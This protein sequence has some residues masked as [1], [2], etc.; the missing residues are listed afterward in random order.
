MYRFQTNISNDEYDTFVKNSSG[1]SFMQDY[2]WSNVKD[3]FNKILCGIYDNEQL[4]CAFTVLIRKIKFNIK[5]MYIPRGPQ[6]D[7][8]NTK[9]LLFFKTNVKKLAIEYKA[10]T[11]IIDPNFCVNEK[12]FK[13]IDNINNDYPVNFAND[14]D[15]KHHNIL[16]VG[17]IHKGFVKGL[18]ESFQ[19]RY[20]MVINLCDNQNNILNIDEVTKNYKSKVRYYLGDFH[21]KRG[22][23][24]IRT[25]SP[26]DV[27]KFVEML[28]YTESRQKIHLRNATYFKKILDNFKERA[29]LVFGY[30]DLNKYLIYLKQNN[31]KEKDILEIEDL[32]KKDDK[33]LLSASLTILPSNNNGIKIAEYLYAGNNLLLPNLRISTGMVYELMNLAI[34][35]KCHYLNLGGVSGYLNDHLTEFKAK[36]NPILFE[37][38][39][40]YELIIN[41]PIYFISKI[42]YKT[43]CLIKRKKKK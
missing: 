26:K 17:F 11:I 16:N 36:F 20:N 19:P 24:F 31:S 13:N 37:Y 22:V 28:N 3:N 33:I 29:V 41:K 15:E 5:L 23:Y 2:R 34:E 43:I 6:L 4:I 8:K 14:F 25:S 35:N 1:I 10:F 7:F 21:K 30:L 9:L 32:L 40:E 42:G 27:D 12:P 18:D 38:A 39:G